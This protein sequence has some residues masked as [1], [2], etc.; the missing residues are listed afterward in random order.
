MGAKHMNAIPQEHVLRITCTAPGIRNHNGTPKPVATL[1]RT[2]N[3]PSAEVVED[4]IWVF[5][6]WSRE[7]EFISKETCLAFWQHVDTDH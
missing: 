5:C 1:V 2:G 4:G 6:R 3:E 7:M